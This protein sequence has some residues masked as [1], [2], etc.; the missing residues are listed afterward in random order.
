MSNL[1]AKTAI[2]IVS[3]PR[4]EHINA[5]TWLNEAT[6]VDVSFYLIKLAAY[7]I[8]DSKPAPLFTMIAGPN[9]ETKD[10]GRQTKDLAERHVLRLRFWEQLLTMAKIK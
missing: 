8:G 10:F 1:D 5:I 9:E 7:R 2:W 3:E 6:P 4:P